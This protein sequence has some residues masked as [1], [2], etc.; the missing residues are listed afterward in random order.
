MENLG[1]ARKEGVVYTR[2]ETVKFIL[3]RIGYVPEKQLCKFSILEPAAGTGAFIQEIVARLL[4]SQGCELSSNLLKD[5]IRAVELEQDTCGAL[6]SLV[7]SQLVDHGMKA[8][9]ADI[10]VEHWIVNADYLTWTPD[11]KFDFVCG[12]PPYIRGEVVAKHGLGVQGEMSRKADIYIQFFMKSLDEMKEGGTHSFICSERWTRNTFGKVLREKIVEDY[13]LEEFHDMYH[14]EPFEEK[15]L[16]YPAITVIAKAPQNPMV[17]YSS[18]TRIP[19]DHSDFSLIPASAVL[20]RQA[21]VFDEG[22]VTVLEKLER[23]HPSICEAGCHMGIG[24]ATGADDVFIPDRLPDIEPERLLPVAMSKNRHRLMINPWDKDGKLVDLDE[25]P[26]TKAWMEM[27]YNRLSRRHCAQ[28]GAWY[29]TIDKPIPWLLKSRKILIPDFGRHASLTIDMGEEYPHHNLYWV[30]SESWPLEALVNILSGEIV[31][32]M[33]A[34]ISVRMNSGTLRFQTRNLKTVRL[35]FWDRLDESVK[36][37]LCSNDQT[38][39]MKA[40]MVAYGLGEHDLHI[41]KDYLRRNL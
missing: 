26:K 12:N 3:D 37:D 39:I 28:R 24:I 2:S 5:C 27:H 19:P 38:R 29:R 10:L 31:R 41:M 7:F 9:D 6:R 20:S 1:K 18:V 30:V 21:W 23:N 16:A 22:A 33:I 13:S 36:E 17:C 15:V 34:A 8:R 40:T 32:F 14:S 11:I 25:W 4:A 35:P